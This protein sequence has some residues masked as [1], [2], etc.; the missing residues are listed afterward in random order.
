MLFSGLIQLCPACSSAGSIRGEKLVFIAH[1]LGH[2]TGPPCTHASADAITIA[3][4]LKFGHTATSS[5][6]LVTTKH[7][8]SASTA[9][10]SKPQTKRQKQ[11]NLLGHVFRGIDIPFSPNETDAIQAQALRATISANLSFRAFEDPEV[12]KLFWMMRTAAPGVLP[13]AKVIGGRL[14]N[15]AAAVVEKK[16]DR[17]LKGQSVGLK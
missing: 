15:D 10:I 17:L 2:G 1:L 14:L 13:S 3:T 9:N 6:P 12:V 4:E 8:R 5:A 11:S 7:G 16:M